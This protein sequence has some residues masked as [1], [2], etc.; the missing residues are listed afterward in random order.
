M[1]NDPLMLSQERPALSAKITFWWSHKILLLAMA[2]GLLVAL[3]VDRWQTAGI[4]VLVSTVFYILFTVYK[5]S[6]VYFSV[7]TG[8]QIRITDEE[9]AGL[10]GAALPVYSVLVPMYHEGR[11]VGP[12]V[13][14]LKKM[15]YPEKKLDVQLLVEEDDEETRTAVDLLTLPDSFRVTMIPVSM[16]RTKPRRAISGWTTRRASTWSSTMRRTGR[17][18][19]S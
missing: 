7:A 8:A 6:L 18:R 5:L 17:N 16:P 12:M 9:L 1:Q 14:A 10:K 19:I 15:D 2:L 4:L 11:S 3:Y 13:E